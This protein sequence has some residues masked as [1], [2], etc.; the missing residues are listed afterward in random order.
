MRWHHFYTRDIAIQDYEQIYLRQVFQR[1]PGQITQACFVPREGK[2]EA[3]Y[4]EEELR[5]WMQQ[6]AVEFRTASKQREKHLREFH[7]SGVALVQAAR[8]LSKEKNSAAYEHFFA[9]G[10]R[11]ATFIWYPWA[12][13]TQV[14]PHFILELQEVFPRDWQEIYESLALTPLLSDMQKA[15]RAVWQWRVRGKKPVELKRLAARYGYLGVYSVRHKVWDEAFFSRM[16]RSGDPRVA[17]Q[18]QAK[19]LRNG[20]KKI[21]VA[22]RRLRPYSELQR[23]GLLIN[24]YVWLRTNRADVYRHALAVMQ[25]FYRTLE[26]KFAWPFGW[27]AHLT[28][29]EVRR[30][31]GG[32]RAPSRTIM[33]GRAT[34]A[35]Y[36]VWYTPSTTRVIADPREQ[37]TFL[38][39]RVPEASRNLRHEKKVM[40]SVAFAGK[41]RGRVRIISLARNA[42]Q[43]R[44]GE[45][46]IA[47]TTQPD[48]MSAIRKA[49]AI[50]TDEGGILSHAAVISRE[51]KIPCIIGTGTATKVFKDGDMVEVDADKG[52]VNKL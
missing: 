51:L 47:N 29:A 43:M 24:D 46:L 32:G 45:I 17:L 27:A 4:P 16:H 28:Q 8:R 41:V 44:A 18:K 39:S 3:W 19:Q 12:V 38:K 35:Q 11:F 33:A 36:V 7:D 9:V 22:L 42:H 31:L 26:K 5:R 20:K 30:M 50:V 6:V 2:W 23:I 48:F 1:W 49:A 37:Q 52:I 21:A 40:G 13:T 15:E 14:E 25:P 34:S 10:K